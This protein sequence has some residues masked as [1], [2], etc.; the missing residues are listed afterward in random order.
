M[1]RGS[2]TPNALVPKGIRDSITG[3][4]Y[5]ARAASGQAAN[6]AEE[7]DEVAPS[8]AKLPVRDSLP[9]GS[10]VRHSKIDHRMVEMGHF[11]RVDMFSP[12]LACPLWLR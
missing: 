3:I 10:V 1:R 8:H 5:C 11:R 7:C 12:L 4:A 6:A 2:N 9:K